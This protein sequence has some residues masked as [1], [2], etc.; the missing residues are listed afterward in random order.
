[1]LLKLI[2]DNATTLFGILSLGFIGVGV[3]KGIAKLFM[4]VL[5]SKVNKLI[6]KYIPEGIALGDILKGEK[7]NEERLYQA[8]VTIENKVLNALPNSLKGMADKLIDSRQ[9]AKEIERELNKR[10][11]EG[12]AQPTVEQ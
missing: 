2:A 4:F 12:L 1:M 5:N 10:K 6:V 9:I 3:S 7:P 11:Y 8:V